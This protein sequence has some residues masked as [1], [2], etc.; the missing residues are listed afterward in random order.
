[1]HLNNLKKASDVGTTNNKQILAER[2]DKYTT[3]A[4]RTITTE[5]KQCFSSLFC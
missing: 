5:K 1:M 4:K 3:Y 2:S